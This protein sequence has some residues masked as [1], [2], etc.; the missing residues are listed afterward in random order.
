MSNNTSIDDTF[1]C[2]LS[3]HNSIAIIVVNSFFAVFGATENI[4][5]LMTVLFTPRLRGSNVGISIAALGFSDLVTTSIGHSSFAALM[6]SECQ[7]E[8]SWFV[9]KPTS[10][11]SCGVSLFVLVH[12]SVDR[13]L[14]ICS[15]FRYKIIVT[16]SRSKT[17]LS[18]LLVGTLIPVIGSLF[19]KVAFV[20]EAYCMFIVLFVCFV[21]IVACYIT[22]LVRLVKQSHVRSTL[23]NEHSNQNQST[24]QTNKRLAKTVALVIGAFTLSWSPLAFVLVNSVATNPFASSTSAWPVTVGLMSSSCNPLIYFYRSEEFRVATKDILRRCGCPVGRASSRVCPRRALA[25]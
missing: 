4:I 11:Y 16:P 2:T 20:V 23:Q 8:M 14:A 22:I 3:L 10:Y 19:V 25:M 1:R 12:M 21:V 24:F 18:C 5:V 15:P 17:V 9:F 13:C 7:N 6:A